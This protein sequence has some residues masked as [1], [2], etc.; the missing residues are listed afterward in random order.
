MRK[1]VVYEFE[2][3]DQKL[4]IKNHGGDTYNVFFDGDEI[5]VFTAYAYN[6]RDKELAVEDWVTNWMD[7]NFV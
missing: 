6:E 1:Y 7:E 4:V 5:D 2:V 3:G